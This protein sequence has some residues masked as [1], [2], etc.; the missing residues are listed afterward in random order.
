MKTS[1]TLFFF[2]LSPIALATA[3]EPPLAITNRDPLNTTT[4][5]AYEEDLPPI[6]EKRKACSGNRLQTDVCQGNLIAR[7][8]SFHNWCASTPIPLI[9]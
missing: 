9:L 4:Q 2:F 7:M 5:D 1:S 3:T 6:L 8:N